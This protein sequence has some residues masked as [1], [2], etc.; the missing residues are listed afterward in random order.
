MRQGYTDIFHRAGGFYSTTSDMAKIGQSILSNTILS[1][2]TTRKWMK[3][4]SH[5][6]DLHSSVGMPWE[7]FRVTT[8]N[9]TRVVDLYTKTGDIGLYAAVLVLIP[10]YNAG[11]VMNSAGLNSEATLAPLADLIA[12]TYLPALEQAAR[13]QTAAN[14]AGI[15]TSAAPLN[16]SLALAVEA[17]KPG[18]A[19][20][21]FVSNGTDVLP[22]LAQ[23][24]GINPRLYPTDLVTQTADGG[25]R[26]VYRALF[27]GLDYA[28]TGVISKIIEGFSW[29]SVDAL[30]YGEVGLDEFLITFDAEGR[31]V[32]VSPRAFRVTLSRS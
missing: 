29:G 31:A 23:L 2:A 20:K 9:S 28:G 14:I 4:I 30:M 17:G 27:N 18:L 6:S 21:S 32:A 7:I 16:S 8:D 15:Y 13:E 26:V 24:Y 22:I 11:F 1:P 10:D 19:L 25:K 12:D 3:P 5:T